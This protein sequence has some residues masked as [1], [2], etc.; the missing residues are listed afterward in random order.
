MSIRPAMTLTLA[1]AGA[2][3]AALAGGWPTAKA[4]ADKELLIG[5]QCDRT[6]PTQIV[7]IRLCAAVQDYANL[8]NSKGGI[9]GYQVRV[10][11]LDNE[12]KVPPAI[13][14]YER[15]KADG[16]ISIMLYGTPQTEALNKKLEE[17]KLPGTSPGF[18]SAAAANGTKYP[19]LFPIAATYWSQAAAAVQFAKQ[20][21][22]NDLHGKK[23]AY[24]FYDNPAGK[25]PMPILDELQKREGFELRTFAVP[26]PGVE[27]G[28]Q[29]LDIAQ[30]YRPDFVLM[31]LFG[32][33]PSVAIKELKRAGYPLSKAIGFVWASA[34][35]DIEA[36]G[37]WPVAEGYHVIQFAGVGDDYSVRQDIRAMYKAEGKDAPK[38]MDSTVY[39]NRGLF[40]V[41][42]HIEAIRNALKG[43]GGTKPSGTDVKKGFEAIHDFTLGGLVPPLR[44]TAA[45]H[46]GGGWV[47]IF[48]VKSGKFAKETDWFRGYPD[49]VEAAVAKGE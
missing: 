33:A 49:V 11:E 13:E 12:Y 20:Q 36:A 44:I 3:A 39:Y 29:V 2:T 34:E 18:G 45:D 46:E 47:Q 40:D 26:P 19:Y 9:E 24:L 23:I 35:A 38:E 7:G 22:A 30:R 17:D 5:E 41:A 28:A 27:M 43:N 8:V 15:E 21:L 10:E 48:Q 16:A 31:H 37:G 25:E 14:E 1:A 32:R 4:A 6:G 42:I